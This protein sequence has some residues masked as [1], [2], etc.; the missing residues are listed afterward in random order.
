[1]FRPTITTSGQEMGWVY[2]LIII[3]INN[4]LI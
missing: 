1:M 4:V 3:I 2:L